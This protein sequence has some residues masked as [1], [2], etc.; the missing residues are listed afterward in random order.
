MSLK[1]HASKFSSDKSQLNPFWK[2]EVN[3]PADV[4]LLKVLGAKRETNQQGEEYATLALRIEVEIEGDICIKTWNVT[5]EKL[6]DAL[7][8]K[9]IEDGSTFTILAK[10]EG[11][12]RK[13]DISNVVNRAVPNAS[14]EPAEPAEPAEAQSVAGIAGISIAA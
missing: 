4:R 8:E 11:V 12:A 9:G 1:D 6:S 14:L 7:V 2:P 13:Y 5:S 3:I 10:G